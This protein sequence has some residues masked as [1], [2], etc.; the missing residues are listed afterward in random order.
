[1]YAA[2]REGT[3]W[4]YIECPTAETISTSSAVTDENT[5]IKTLTITNKTVAFTWGTFFGSVSPATFY[6]NKFNG[7][8]LSTLAKASVEIEKE[9]AAMSE[10]FTTDKAGKINVVLSLSKSK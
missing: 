8:S 7:Q 9:L 3:S 6:N 4:T 1:M 10:Y 5:G 2:K